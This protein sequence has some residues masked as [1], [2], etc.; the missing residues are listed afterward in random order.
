MT[1]QLIQQP[2]QQ[3][4]TE[5]L[6]LRRFAM[7]D[8]SDLLGL[9]SD[10]ELLRYQSWEAQDE[11]A[12]RSFLTA[13]AM[14]TLGE[15]GKWFQF[16][17]TLRTNGELIGDCG[18]H[19]LAE[20]PRQGEIGYTFARAY[21]GQGFAQ[22][23]VDALLTYIFNQLDL[24]RIAAITDMRNMASIK[25]LER[26]GFRREGLTR[27][28]FWNKGEWVD[29]YIYAT[30]RSEWQN[31]TLTT[32]TTKVVLLGTGTPNPDPER[33]GSAAAVVVNRG[34]QEQAYLVDCGPGIVRRAAA[35]AQKGIHALAMPGLTRL[36]LTHHHSDHTAGLPDLILSPWVIG[37]SEPLVIYGPEGTRAMVEH[38]L[39]AYSEDL[40]ERREG[41]EPSNACGCH[42]EVHDYE[43]GLI[44]SDDLVQV[45]AFR[46]QHGSWPAF[47]LRF[48]TADRVVVFSGDTRPFPELANHYRDCD[49]L[50]HE[51]YSTTGLQRRPPT[52]QRYHTAVHTS[53]EELAALANAVQPTLLVLVHQLFWGVSDDALVAEIQEWYGGRVV[54]GHDLAIY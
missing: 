35:A 54:S 9:R 14:A 44:Y 43:A 8:L 49:V 30:L 47:G 48:T 16:A 36:F 32:D 37:R 12:I 6:I 21:Q 31:R 38:L 34:E 5:R 52:W 26:L 28:A 13:M 19:L 27:Q 10:P 24:H 15:P 22:E 45:E 17:V 39:A 18:L 42:V 1:E 7:S 11:A 51:V 41:L 33:H 3:L 25:L 2:F 29:E 4:V 20:D 53:T 23:A 46:V 40:R 50:V